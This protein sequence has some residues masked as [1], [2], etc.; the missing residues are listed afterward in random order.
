MELLDA[1]VQK[2]IATKDM[3]YASLEGIYQAYK[4][5]LSRMNEGYTGLSK[6]LMELA[7]QKIIP[8]VKYL[9][10]KMWLNGISDSVKEVADY[11]KQLARLIDKDKYTDILV[12]NTIAAK[13]LLRNAMSMSKKAI[14]RFETEEGKQDLAD[15][16]RRLAA[17]RMGGGLTRRTTNKRRKMKASTRKVRKAGKTRK[18]RKHRKGSKTCR[19]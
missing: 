15:L 19:H 5:Y 16:E 3:K 12:N 10:V 7:G 2:L 18:E 11:G 6:V 8:E 1:K 9:E 14:S 13:I 17:L 4:I